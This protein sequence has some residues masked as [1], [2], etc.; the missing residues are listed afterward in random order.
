[1][2]VKR[3]WRVWILLAIFLPLAALGLVGKAMQCAMMGDR[4]CL[5]R[6]TVV[7]LLMILAGVCS[8]VAMGWQQY[9]KRLGMTFPET[10]RG[11]RS[12]ELQTGHRSWPR[13]VT[14]LLGF[15]LL[16]LALWVQFT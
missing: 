8:A 5:D 9:A 14:A 16:G 15:V 1:M 13:R 12:G 11:Y 6:P 10:Y 7:A 3:R 2:N 4:S